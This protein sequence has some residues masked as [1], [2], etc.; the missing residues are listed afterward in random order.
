[1]NALSLEQE[2]KLQSI[3]LE[4]RRNIVEMSYRAGKNCAHCG[5]SLSCV[6]ILVTLY[7]L[8]ISR[9]INDIENRDRVILS[10]AHASLAMY[11]V[12]STKGLISR[13]E[14]F[15]F[16]QNGSRYTAHAHM[17][18]SKG[19]EFT[20]GSLGLGLSYAVG[21][22]YALNE[23]KSQ[24]H[25]YVIVGD[26]E[27]DEGIVW[28]SLMFVKHHNL[29]NM[30][31]IVDHNHLQ[32]DGPIEDIIDTSSLKDR[33]SSFGLYTQEVDGHSIKEF[34]NA[35][36]QRKESVPNAIIAETIK[37][38]GI[39]F[40]EKK[41]NWHFASLAEGRYRKAMADLGVNLEG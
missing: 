40:M 3:S 25:V 9:D 19:L 29:S 10:K 39:S 41:A 31:I 34:A 15:T 37:G 7:H 16:E 1:M 6:E 5:G 21:M 38:K 20:G 26:G 27:C 4:A 18:I 8:F 30:T 28:E 35:L 33:F 24:A 2:Q 23:R 14:L 36:S 11:A 32:A 13:D 12:L 22:A 17:D